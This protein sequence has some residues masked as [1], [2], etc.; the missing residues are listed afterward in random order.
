MRAHRAAQA[1]VICDEAILGGTPVVS[2]TRV[3]AE[4]VLAE[5]RTGKSRFEIFRSYPSLPPDGIDACLNWE[6]AGRPAFPNRVPAHLIQALDASLDDLKHDRTSDM[7]QFLD[8]MQEKIDAATAADSERK[9]AGI[10]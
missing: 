5:V 9:S 7:G 10:D 4:T 8:R 2:G 1:A 6:R 3:P